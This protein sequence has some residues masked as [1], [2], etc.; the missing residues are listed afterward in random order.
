MW[1][2]DI[3]YVPIR[4]GF[5]YLV[6]VL[7]WFS[8]YV[9]ARQLSNTLDGYFCLEALQQALAFATPAIFNTNQGIQFA[10]AAFVGCLETS[11]IRVSMDGRG[12]A[13]DNVF[14]ERLWR[15]VKYED[16]YFTEYGIVS[17]LEAGLEHYFH[18]Y[19]DQRPHQSLVYHTPA[20]IHFAL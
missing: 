15:T 4:R 20:E 1:S 6:A 9:L 10:T 3:T 17:E 14:V 5:M 18:F 16:I 13:L 7:D 11:G 2:A 19:N 12:R 8:R